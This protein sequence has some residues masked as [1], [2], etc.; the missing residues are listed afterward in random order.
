MHKITFLLC[1]NMLATSATLPFEMLRAAESAARAKEGSQVEPVLIQT[2]SIDKLPIK[3]SIGFSLLPDTELADVGDSDIIY[4]PALWRNPR[5]IVK[6]HPEI[7]AWLR[8]AYENGAM[9]SAVGTGCCFLA[10]AGLLNDKP[11]TT[12]WHYFDQFQ[13][14]YPR[15]KLKR[16][17]FITQASNLYCSASVNAMADLTVH[18]VKRLY[19]EAIA[20]VVERNFSHEIRRPYEKTSYF[21]GSTKQHPDEEIVQAQ[22]WLQDNYNRQISLGEVAG[23]FEM[24]VRTFNRRFK[25]ATGQTPL[26]YLQKIRIEIA[27][28]LLQTSNLNVSEVADKIGYQDVGYFT[29]LFVKLLATS[30]RE[31]RAT[32]RAKL[33]TAD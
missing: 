23:R 20:S 1:D 16:Q 29:S 22:I 30:P 15:V 5:T 17:Y 12:H 24:S 7:L 10:E 31:Y 18:F 21:E 3:T 28:D 4:L 8:K 14:D 32:V 2:T 13:R 26:Q 9:L 27:K 25:N 11:A 6:K 33:F 19:G